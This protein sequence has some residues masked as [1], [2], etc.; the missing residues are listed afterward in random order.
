MPRSED[1][2][3]VLWADRFDE[4]ATAL[5]VT[6]LR[7]AGLRV[8][9]LSMNTH[10]TAGAHGLALVPD[11]TLEQAMPLAGRARCVVVP[12]ETGTVRTLQDDPRVQDFLALA[13]ANG[14]CIVMPAAVTPPAAASLHSSFPAGVLTYEVG[15]DVVRIARE[16]ARRLAG[17]QQPTRAG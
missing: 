15:Q 13:S 11:L 2:T 12:A 7:K 17:T 5:F 10:V 9:L 16:L 8:R 1:L 14:A 6:E 4:A 3:F